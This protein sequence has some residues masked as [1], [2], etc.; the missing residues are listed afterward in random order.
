[1]DVAEAAEELQVSSARVRALC[2]AGALAA[3]RKGGRWLIPAA[4]VFE[5]AEDGGRLR[6]GRPPAPQTVW[7]LLAALDG[8]DENLSGRARERALRLIARVGDPRRD[9]ARWRRLLAPRS[10][11]H[12]V[13]VHPGVLQRLAEDPRVHRGGVVAAKVE[14]AGEGREHLYLR[15]S[16]LDVVLR[17]YRAA[18]DP[19]GQVV[20]HV[21]D[22]DLLDGGVAEPGR[23]AGAADLLSDF[24][25]RASAAGAESLAELHM[26]LRRRLS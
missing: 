15:E 12:R 23:A 18:P 14:L 9:R 20:L 2:A 4:A 11:Q 25:P 3:E 8:N 6:P 5:R 10:Q 22:D 24:D 7:N 16:D 19:G 1:M 17:G 21:V 26:N 13:R